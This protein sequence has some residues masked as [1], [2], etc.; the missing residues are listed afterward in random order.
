MLLLYINTTLIGILQKQIFLMFHQYLFQF[1][2]ITCTFNWN[3]ADVFVICVSLYLTSRLQQINYRINAVMGKVISLIWNSLHEV[4]LS[5]TL[6]L[7]YVT[8]YMHLKWEMEHLIILG[9]IHSQF[10]RFYLILTI[11]L[12]VKSKSWSNIFLFQQTPA[13]FWRTMR[14]D[15]SRVSY[16]VKRIDD[17]IS[18]IV[19]LSF[20]NN[21]FFIC[22]QLL[23]TLE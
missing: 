21:L 1:I 2:N 9:H 10:K 7:L 18:G 15:Y 12:N 17:A 23:H 19:F 16:L 22:L 11:S 8:F 5:C 6:F 4:Y 3:F 13:S 20:A 14:E